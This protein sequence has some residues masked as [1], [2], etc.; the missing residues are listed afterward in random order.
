L[1]EFVATV[2]V[3]TLAAGD[4]LSECLSSLSAQSQENFQVI[5]VDNSGQ[6]LVRQGNFPGIAIIEMDQNVGFGAAINAA[7]EASDSP[8]L[9]TLNDDAVAHPQWLE[10]LV[11]AMQ[12]NPKTGSCASQVRLYGKAAGSQKLL[13]SAGMLICGDGSSKQRGHLRPPVEFADSCEVLMPSASA[14]LYRRT[15]LRETGGFDGE[16]FLYCEDTDLGLRAIRA[17]WT[18]RY[19]AEAVVDHRYSHSAGRVSPLKAY[20][21]ERNRIALA[22]KNFPLPM[23][24][25][26]PLI[27]LARYFWHLIALVRGNGITAEF[28]RDGNGGWR[29]G[30]YVVKAHFSALGRLPQ[31]LRQRRHIAASAKIDNISFA[32][33]L[34]RFSISARRVAE[35]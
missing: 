23:L 20:F 27:A 4:T 14:A 22:I 7:I 2:V 21:V 1:P 35:L 18:S 16:F 24:I 25:A 12:S 32:A 26:A 11:S 6:G 30:W 29:L 17:G 28:R 19:V 9:A 33:K 34:R 13:D 5:V 3:P 15:M 31:L 8:Y 10:R